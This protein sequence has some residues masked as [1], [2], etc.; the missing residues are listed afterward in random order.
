MGVL[1][2]VIMTIHE[3]LDWHPVVLIVRLILK[4]EAVRSSETSVNIYQINCK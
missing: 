2:E 3:F 4:M 1:V